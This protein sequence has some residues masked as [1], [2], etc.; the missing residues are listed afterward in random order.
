KVYLGAVAGYGLLGGPLTVWDPAT[1]TVESFHHVVKDQSVVSLTTAGEL[2]VGGTTVGGGGGSHPTE[3]EA[4]LFVWDPQTKEKVFET[5]PVPGASEITN[6]I[7]APNGRV[8]GMAGSRT[9]FVF[10][11]NTRQILHCT[12][13]PFRAATGNTYNSVALGPD[14]QIWGVTGEG[15]FTI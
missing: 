2:I 6:L 15:I 4:R 1:Q 3:K 7:T 12:A 5:V 13:L 8:F 11:T 10:D 14:K 9:L